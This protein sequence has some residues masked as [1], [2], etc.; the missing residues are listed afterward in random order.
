MRERTYQ[1]GSSTITLVF[2][3]LVRSKAEVLVSS[4][5]FM[6]SM[7]GGVSEAI[8]F[9]AG[10]RIE[11]ETAKMVP[12][13]LGDIVV[14]SACRHPAR[15][16][17]HAVTIGELHFEMA[18]HAILRYAVS[19]TISL[20]PL[21]GCRSIAFPI[22]GTGVAGIPFE[23]AASEMTTT[24]VSA[25][26]RS[27]AAL[28]IEVYFWQSRGQAEQKS[29][30]AEFEK[31][32]GEKIG[33]EAHG[34]GDE[35]SLDAPAGGLA[36]G[37]EPALGAQ[38]REPIHQMLK[39]LDARR[40]QLE[41]ALIEIIGKGGFEQVDQVQG[42]RAQLENVQLLRSGYEAELVGRDAGS[43][44]P[45]KNSVFVSSTSTDLSRH[46]NSVRDAIEGLGMT[47][48]GMEDFTP[49]E[50]PPADLIRQKVQEAEIY[51]GIIGMR[52]GY[53][54]PS[55]GLSM[56]ELE[57]RQAVASGKPIRIFLM[58]KDARITAGMVESEPDAFAKLLAFRDQVAK[59]HT[60][61]FF[62]DLE[63]LQTKARA[64]LSQ[65]AH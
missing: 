26:V 61:G 23:T 62:N 30:L 13:R 37:L 51:L 31:Q 43:S 35:F 4:D 59:V 16:V 57:Y 20:A 5:D 1:I 2:G 50:K 14:T 65:E 46:R 56:T 28:D 58:D 24:L 8:R 18:Q 11:E 17:F 21:L 63:D 38:R 45:I 10:K 7:G 36:P 6:L 48:I 52:Y 53:V 15:Y 39:H 64:T 27:K 49:T 12:A 33:L 54:E 40:D 22:L 41:A 47:F 42:L 34:E 32:V 55:S 29:R 60:C 9:R 44:G 19:K 25:L 3:D